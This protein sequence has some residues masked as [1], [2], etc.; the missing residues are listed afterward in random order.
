VELAA[1]HDVS[2]VGRLATYKYIDSDVAV[3]QALDFVKETFG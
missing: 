2:L 3:K 1:K